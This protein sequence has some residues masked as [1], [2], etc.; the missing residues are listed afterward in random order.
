MLRIPHILCVFRF[1]KTI[2]FDETGALTIVELWKKEWNKWTEELF[3]KL[4]GLKNTLSG[5]I[6]S[7]F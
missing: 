3:F 1:N 7:V 2:V 6:F 4:L 5:Q